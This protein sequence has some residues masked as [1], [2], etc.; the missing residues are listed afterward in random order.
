MATKD[1]ALVVV[2]AAPDRAAVDEVV[3]RL[4]DVLGP[5]DRT[6]WRA[7]VGRPAAGAAGVVGSFEQARRALELGRRLGAGDPVADAA[8]LLVHEVLL[9]DP[10]VAQDLVESTLAPL[11]QVRGGVEPVLATLEAYLDSGG[12]ATETARRLHLSVRAVT[13]RLARVR[14][15]TG[16]DATRAEHRFGLQAAVLAARA[17]GWPGERA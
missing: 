4:R 16:I 13:Y 3:L 7:G 9:R 10:G 11:R 12:N 8:D 5:P 15:L 17:L 14:D 6:A 1:G 2:F